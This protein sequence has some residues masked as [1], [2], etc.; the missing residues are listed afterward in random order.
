MGQIQSKI[1]K[2]NTKIQ[3]K[4]Q[5]FIKNGGI[6]L[7][8][9][10]ALSNGQNNV[11]EQQLKIVS[12]DEIKSAT[13][14][15]DTGLI[16]HRLQTANVYRCTLDD[17]NVIIKI[18]NELDQI[19]NPGL[20]DQFLT[21]VTV[22]VILPHDNMNNVYGCCLETNLPMIVYHRR[23][24]R[25]VLHRY[26]H[27]ELGLR[28]VLTWRGRVKVATGVGYALC[29]MHN[30]LSKP[31][32]HRDVK[33]IC[34]MI[35]SSFH[36]VLANVSY[37]VSIA[38]GKKDRSWPVHGTPGY[39]DPEYAETR[40]LT[41]K[42][43]VYSFGVLMLELLTAMDPC[44]MAKRGKDLV[45]EFVSRV[46]RSGGI[47][48]MIDVN[49][50]EEGNMEEIQRFTRLALQCVAKKGEERPTMIS[51][52]GELWE[53]QNQDIGRWTHSST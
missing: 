41:D 12:E 20:V 3:S 5:N 40:E 42:C 37:A 4:E 21:D 19:Q 36:A 39:I 32:I 16:A 45:D 13:N 26:L 27:V 25:K 8:K 53:I 29:Y 50:A 52:V 38:P 14:N 48:E 17:R 23:S 1:K 9:Q 22:A 11:S 2:N 6:L 51:V 30:A 10:I 34:V 35:D 28:R 24:M 47:K 46:G 18:P 43:D 31:V 15:Y 44:E 7:E 33:S 49:A